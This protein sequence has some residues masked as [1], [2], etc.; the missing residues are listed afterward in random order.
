MASRIAEAYV[1]ITPRIDGVASK[2]SNQLSTEMGAVG[3]V[4]GE[5]LGQGV[6]SRFAVS[7][8]TALL[9]GFAAASAAIFGFAKSAITSASNFEESANAIRVA[10]GEAA[11]D[12]A[13]LGEGVA[14]RLGLSS[15]QFNQAAVRFS[16]FAGRIAGEGGN[17]AGVVDSLTTRAA[18]FASVFNIDVSEAL[19]VFQSGLAG[20]AEPLKRFGINLLDTEVKTF[21][22]ANGIA[23]VGDE[24]TETQKVQARYGLLLQETAKTQGDFANTSDS[25]ANATRILN[26]NIEQLRIEAGPGLATAFSV[27]VQA[28]TPLVQTL[29]PILQQVFNALSPI[30]ISLASF[31]PTVAN[32]FVGLI[33]IITL[34]FD[35]LTLVIEA[36]LPFLID[37]FKTLEPILQALLPPIV[38]IVKALLPIIPAVLEIVQAFLPLVMLILPLLV[39][40]LNVLTPVLVI[41][42]KVIA[43]VVGG[44]VS[45]LTGI[46]GGLLGILTPVFDVFKMVF[47]GIAKIVVYVGNIIIGGIELMVNSIIDGLNLMIGALNKI[48]IKAPDWLPLIGGKTFSLNLSKIGKASIGRIPQL[49]EGGFVDNPTTALIG[50]AGPEVVMPLNRFEQLMGI[51]GSRGQTINYYAAPNQSLDAEQALLQAVKR[52]RVITGW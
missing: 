14:T 27:L 52:A 34:L 13:K 7:M 44:A 50:E 25:L 20:E 3:A 19:A 9:V 1:Q 49:A 47:E 15:T 2:L 16:A 40:L 21:A 5:A 33:P 18:D 12:V 51:N 30:F 45:F 4:G 48:Q 38:E 42:A 22:Y 8:K 32:L 31:L 6:G 28:A 11:D 23:Q 24:L 26:A 46:L 35:A 36:A 17:V 41:V 39:T 37:L 29:G 10:Y 43:G